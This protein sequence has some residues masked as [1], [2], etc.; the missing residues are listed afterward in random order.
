MEGKDLKH[1][2][3]IDDDE[4]TNLLHGMIIREVFPKIRVST[5]SN[6]KEALDFIVAAN[7]DDDLPDLI[8]LD[9]NMP[10]MDGWEFIKC[11]DALGHQI[12]NSIVAFMIT[13]SLN[14]MDKETARSNEHID[15][16]ISKPISPEILQEICRDYFGIPNKN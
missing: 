10:V 11:Y 7:E 3:L 1:V 16:F 14:D 13:S 8:F 2:L 4:T 9:I 5:A 6:G 15:V 12:Q